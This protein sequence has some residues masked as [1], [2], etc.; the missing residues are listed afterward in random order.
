MS[1]SDISVVQRI[2]ELRELLDRANFAYYAEASSFMTDGEYDGLIAQ[3]IE[4]ETKHPE[5]SDT[6]SPSTRVGGVRAEGFTAVKHTL[7]MTSIDNTYSIESFLTW[8]DRCARE[9]GHPAQFYC[10]PKIDGLAISLRYEK[11]LLVQ[12]VTRGDGES[13]DDVT[14]NVRAIRAVPLRLRS[15][16]GST[17]PVP[18]VLEVRGEIFMPNKQ[19]ERLNHAR[20]AAGEPAFANARN[21]TAGTMKSLDPQVV[22]DR[23][24]SFIAHGR[25]EL[26]GV[27]SLSF[28]EF[29]GLISA[30][31]IP[32]NRAGKLC[33]DA[34][35][36]AQ[37]IEAFRNERLKVPYGIDGM[38]VRVDRFDDQAAL[39]VTAKSPR[40]AIAFKYP[41][42]RGET[43]LVG[44]EWQVGKGGTLTPRA[45]MEPVLIAGSMV[46]HAT[47]HNI[48]E[49]RRK[50]IMVGDRVLVEKAGEI[51]PQVVE[52]LV[53]KRT[54]VECAIDA[55][56]VCPACGGAVQMVG[57]KLFCANT[58]C[59]AQIR[60]RLIWFVG[61][62][63]MAIDGMGEKV[64]DQ[65]I[66]AGL[67]RKFADLF[68]MDRE[69]VSA[70]PRL[71]DKSAASIALSAEAAKARGLARLLGG[72]GI[73]HIGTS[74]AKTL[75][76]AY[77]DIESLLAATV[78][79]LQGLDDFGERTAPSVWE[80][81]HSPA[82]TQTFEELRAAGVSL[83][84]TNYVDASR[85]QAGLVDA[86][87]QGGAVASEFA[88]KTV[89]ISGT[90][91]SIGR[92]EL[93]ARIEAL[94]AK[95]SG[96]VSK[97]TSFLI[98][99]AEPGSKLDK[100]RELGVEVWDE[101]RLV[102]ALGSL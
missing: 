27:P 92:S 90:L 57:P 11:G 5:C 31:G 37:S 39:G 28:S 3:L 9:L 35:E 49:I 95:V 73:R 65:L 34:Q 86:S 88:G 52:S 46:R 72:L 97:R 81:L 14:A 20:E 41:A 93:T 100:A 26:A 50:G 59:P 79:E 71:G 94:G 76:K 47:L 4:L 45:T 42:E 2:H 22:V 77:P 51:I 15:L 38:V 80:D 29:L 25:G 10:D 48:E 60:E 64:I 91:A 67:L 40:W 12:A 32:V 69:K 43:T 61:R 33:N 82:L 36:A 18:S 75:G 62:D 98:A 89:V 96:S 13:G 1:G 19:F 101:Q 78:T 83:V 87:A 58:Q 102:R 55:P 68:T 74:A 30:L 84:S 23:R 85:A 66:E 70:L 44:V 7:P 53:N 56:T 63:Q 54:G 8:A 6:S 21:S 16:G 99:G 17:H 24:L